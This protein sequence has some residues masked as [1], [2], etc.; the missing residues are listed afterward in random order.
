MSHVARDT[1]LP[2]VAAGYIAVALLMT[3]PLALGLGRDVPGDLGDALLNMWILAWGFDALPGL[4]TGSLTWTAFWNAPMFH[5]EPLALALSEH[6]IAQVLQGAPVYWL[7]GNIVLTY[8]LLFLSTSVLSALGTY[9]LVRDLTGDWR[10]GV[11]SGLA[12]GFLPYRVAQISHLQVLSTQWMPLALW[13]LHRFIRYG[14]RRALAGGTASLVMLHWSCGYY[15]LF[16]APCVAAFCLHELWRLDQWRSRPRWMGLVVAGA[17]SLALT[18]PVLLPYLDVR[19]TYGFQRGREEILSFSANLWALATGSQALTAWGAIMQAMP[20]PE[21]E[22]FL[23]VTL[24]LLALVGSASAVWKSRSP[25]KRAEPWWRTGLGGIAL[26]WVTANVALFVGTLTM[27]RVV[28]MAGPF[29]VRASSSGRLLLQAALGLVLAAV[30]SPRVRQ[31]LRNIAVTPA[32]GGLL[33]SLFCVWMAMGPR[34]MSGVFRLNDIGLYEMFYDHVPGFDGLRVPARYIMVAGLFLSIVAGT[35]AAVLMRGRRGGLVMALAVAGILVDGAAL[36]FDLNRTWREHEARPPAE[37]FSRRK[38]PPVYRYLAQLPASSVVAEF[39][40]GD[41]AWELRY[42]YAATQHRRT[43]LNGYS[44]WFP[45][46]YVHRVA[47]FSQLPSEPEVA[48]QALVEGQPTHVVL[49]G[50]SF[51]EPERAGIIADWLVAHGATFDR[52]FGDGDVVY[53]MPA[54]R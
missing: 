45:P 43:L 31:R 18:L 53:A 54:R 24:T 9:L 21:G 42:L 13:G 52:A 10:A 39:P 2:A 34:P 30:L 25:G 29:F 22:G 36:P 35:G 11:I 32:A 15:I 26:V 37:V 44:G 5:P 20:V 51:A 16:F 7:T 47:A 46:A 49:H 17:A 38:T 4:L 6:L 19:S 23:G 12:F 3:W 50:R 48:W 8:N 33:L 41:K 28:F 1:R 14:S 27:G 40:F